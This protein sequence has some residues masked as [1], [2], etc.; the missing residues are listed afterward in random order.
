[1]IAKGHDFPGVTLVG[2]LTADQGL[3]LPDFRAAER[4]FQLLTQAAGRAGRGERNGNVV[5][6]TYYPNH[7]SL[8]AARLQDY[9]LF[10]KK[11][12]EFRRRFQ[13]P[14]FSALVNLLVQGKHR[15]PTLNQANNLCRILLENRKQ[16]SAGKRIRI[17][18]PAP[19]P[20]ERI[21]GEYRFQMLIKA[22]QR[23][24]ALQIIRLGLKNLSQQGASLKKVTIDV[25]PVSLL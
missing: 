18:G 16:I 5:I 9:S 2:I 15:E 6:Q 13:Y 24:E 1:M 8:K 4:T 25:D 7:Y 14:P 11:E 22:V 20:L 23:S 3:R 21:K 10:F 17:L 12:I 19:A